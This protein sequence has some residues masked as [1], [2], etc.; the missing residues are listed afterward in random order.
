MPSPIGHAL[1]GI[2]VNQARP[3][4]F[5]ANKWHEAVFFVF[6][7]NL[8]DFDFLPGLL[9]GYPNLY[10]HGIFHSLGAALLVSVAGGWLFAMRKRSFRNVTTVV[11]VMYA[12][13]LLLDFFAGDTKPPYG[14]PLLWPFSNRFFLAARPIFLNI[15]RSSR[16]EDFFSSLFNRH[17]LAAVLLETLILGG[18]A[19]AIWLLRRCRRKAG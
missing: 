17:N 11:F 1:T 6:L 12:V 18:M 15:A 10:H 2:A 3:G 9:T 13:H 14:M 8:P 4:V 5:F 16:S 7:A 19:V